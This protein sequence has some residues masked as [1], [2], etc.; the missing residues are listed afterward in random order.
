MRRNPRSS[1]TPLGVRDPKS[2]T[3]SR[4][5]R[6]DILPAPSYKAGMSAEL[7]T[8]RRVLLLKYLT[9]IEAFAHDILQGHFTTATPQ[10]HRELLAMAQDPTSNRKCVVVPRG[11]GKS[12]TI[13]FLYALWSIVFDR[14]KFIVIVS[15]SHNQSKLF[16]EAIAD[17]LRHNDKLKRLFGDLTTDQWSQESITTA[18]G[19]RVVA[20]GSGQKLRG[21]KYRS[22]RPTL[23]LFDDC[24]NDEL[25]STPEQRAKLKHWF[26][27]A[28]LPAL[29]SDGQCFIV[30]TILHED[31][32]LNNIYER[33]GSFAKAK[34]AALIEGETKSL[35]E[36]YHPIDQLRLERERLL[37]QGLSDVWAQEYMCQAINPDTAEF[38]PADFARY[39][40]SHLRGLSQNDSCRPS[41][42]INNVVHPLN[43]TMAVDPSMGKSRSSDYSAIVTIGSAPD[44]HA[45]ILDVFRR[46]VPPDELIKVLFEKV[47]RFSPLSV[48]IETN[49]FQALLATAINERMRTHNVHFR[50]EEFRTSANKE[51]RI[52]GLVPAVR[53]GTL[54]FPHRDTPC[55]DSNDLEAELGMFPRANH[56]DASDALES[57]FRNRVSPRRRFGAGKPRRHYQPDSAMGGY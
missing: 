38:R 51:V 40:P 3:T 54:L 44:G 41:I 56:D 7:N 16:L 23:M 57:A 36:E 45:Y 2:Q 50:I 25:V 11:F 46:R 8:S 14:Q 19:V 15:D 30:G 1:Y 20:K 55:G 33:D 27:A 43:I 34:Y 10:F 37:S 29:A 5:L 6:F 47:V 24:E 53:S 35:W 42:T 17:E 18:N 22:S 26:Y 48:H 39:D 4:L 49:G 21:L 12:T 32:L 31:S 52:R 13:T 9:D 28:A